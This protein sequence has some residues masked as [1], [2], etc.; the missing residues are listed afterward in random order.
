MSAAVQNPRSSCRRL[1]RFPYSR[2][3]C[4]PVRCLLLHRQPGCCAWPRGAPLAPAPPA[5]PAGAEQG[6]S[7]GGRGGAPAQ[8][9]RQVWS[10][11]AQ[12]AAGACATCMHA[13][14]RQPRRTT[15]AQRTEEG[16]HMHICRARRAAWAAAQAPV[17][18]WVA[19]HA[20]G[21]PAP[22][23][24]PPQTAGSPAGAAA[25]VLLVGRA[26]ASDGDPSRGPLVRASLS[27]GR[28]AALIS[29]RLSLISAAQCTEECAVEA[30]REEDR[31]LA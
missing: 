25:A 9:Q 4:G 10:G 18:R 26:P 14:A 2:S 22:S 7:R 13:S 16:G 5:G 29:A 28:A 19:A 3:Y 27:G 23:P 30:R 11:D 31:D 17:V 21:R 6:R 12:E 15:R 8:R 20:V 24:P 1:R